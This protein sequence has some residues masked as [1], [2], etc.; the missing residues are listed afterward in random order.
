MFTLIAFSES[1]DAAGAEVNV[2]AVTD[3]QITVKD[4]QAYIGDYH[5]LFGAMA[6]VGTT[7]T[8]ARLTSPTLRHFN[9][10]EIAPLELDIHP[11]AN[12]HHCVSPNR[13]IDLSI[14]EGLEAKLTADPAAAEQQTIIAFLSDSDIQQFKGS[15]TTARFSVTLAQ[16]AG[17]W[18]SA[19]IDFN[20]ELQVGRYAIVGMRIVADGAVAARLIFRGATARP[21][22]PCA[23][24]VE[25]PTDTT[26]R[27]GNLGVF[28]EFNSLTPPK[29][30]IIGSAAVGSATYQGFFDLVRL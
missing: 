12:F 26:F 7:G 16:L 22:V 2:A 8:L 20:E 9:S 1:Q 25:E 18:N 29:V 10:F 11:G 21:G 5:K 30:E 6:C 4:D 28:G 13:S 24:T 15:M 14:G 19:E 17:S 3:D 23:A 27:H